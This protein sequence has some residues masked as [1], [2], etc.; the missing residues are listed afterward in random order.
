MIIEA[1]RNKKWNRL[2]ITMAASFLVWITLLLVGLSIPNGA[3]RVSLLAAKIEFFVHFCI[4]FLLIK[5]CRTVSKEDRRAMLWLLVINIWLFL[6]DLFFYIAAYMNNDFLLKMSSI[7]FLLYYAPCIVYCFIMITFLVRILLKD[8]FSKTSGFIYI[9]LALFVVNVVTF[10]LFLSSVHYAYSV[11]SF[12]T[13]SQVLMLSIEL[14]LFDFAILGL[15][16]ANNI[17]AIL[18]L[19]GTI[20]LITGDFFLTYSSISQTVTVFSYGELLWLSGLLFIMFSA[21]SIQ[22]NAHYSVKDWFK[23]STTIRTR[24]AF[25]GFSISI[26]SFLL[27]FVLA[28]AF[29]IVNKAIFISLPLFVMIYSVIVVTLSVWMGRTFEVPFKKIQN[30]IEAIILNNDKNKMQYEFSIEEFIFLQKYIMDTFELRDEKDKMKKK[31]GDIAA[32]VAHDIRSPLTAMNVCL[33]KLPEIPEK[34]RIIL[35]NAANRI[36]DI[37]TNLLHYKNKELTNVADSLQLQVLLIE[38][39]IDAMLSEKR[40]SFD[41]KPIS[42]KTEITDAAYFVFACIDPMEIK[43]VLSNLINNA[44]ESF[45]ET[46]GNIT[47]FLDADDKSIRIKIMDDGCGIPYEKLTTIFES[48][49]TTK[50]DG[51]GIGLSHAKAA[52]EKMKGTITID[53][54]V[55]KGTS[56]SICIPRVA[57][58]IWFISKIC[59]KPDVQIIVLDDDESIH[60]AW[61]T[62]LKELLPNASILHFRKGKEF[63]DWYE[64]SKYLPLLVLSDYELLGELKTGLDIL[65]ELKIGSQGILITSHYEKPEIIERCI[66][67]KIRLLPKN[68]V[69][70][71]P[72]KLLLDCKDNRF[73]QNLKK[74]DY[75]FIDDNQLIIDVWL[76]QAETSGKNV[77]TF[78]SISEA[79]KEIFNY[80]R[81]TPIYIDSTLEDDKKGEEYAKGMYE[82][83]F[84]TIYLATGCDVRE[85][86]TMYWIKAIVGKEP[87]F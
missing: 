39:I 2:S 61:D 8:V 68:L 44:S 51:C 36:N 15:I 3:E 11:L 6:V 19:S 79:E 9:V 13:I 84:K 54:Q 20:L 38:P 28:Y 1:V 45:P 60:G 56:V 58:P 49:K 59:I 46:G 69:T 17:S 52:I 76:M 85:F 26:S 87:P 73:R 81:T 63:I 67:S 23:K 27:F 10:F 70:H 16:Y 57:T 30:N 31:I 41:E 86:P 53:S 35:R 72:I 74:C 18:L 22:Q 65:E 66:E 62:R 82:A 7:K 71:I 25:W 5:I 43:R 78:S 75:I 34:E 50:I 21:I 4:L 48:K 64:N 14:I 33:Q 42:L 80:D 29:S 32:Q 47:V 12:E 55:K 37:A 24:L 77:V 40:F 83:G